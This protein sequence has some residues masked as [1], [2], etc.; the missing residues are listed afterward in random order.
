MFGQRRVFLPS[1][2]KIV[3]AGVMLASPLFLL[4]QSDMSVEAAPA[5]PGNDLLGKPLWKGIA[6][7][8]FAS[9]S[10]TYNTNIPSSR[11]NQFR[12]FDFNDDEP[13]LDVG[14][15]VIQRPVAEPGQFGFRLNMMAGSG[16]P[17]ITAS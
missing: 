13:Q 17:E 11:L 10:Y 14:Q 8:G 9:L 12:V 16:V 1:L 7:D 3:L 5:S 15:L 2:G 6:A 4:A